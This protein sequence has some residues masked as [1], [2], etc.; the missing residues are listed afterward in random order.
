[1][2][3]A[4]ISKGLPNG[5]HGALVDGIVADYVSHKVEFMLRL[6]V[7]SNPAVATRKSRYRRC[8]F[9]IRGLLYLV[10]EFPDGTRDYAREGGLEI[11]GLLDTT[12]DICPSLGAI[13]TKVS[14]SFFFHSFFVEEWNRFIHFSGTDAALD[15]MED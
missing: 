13:R 4:E 2:T 8:R 9:E 3:P 6:L 14:S 12:P 11:N 1:M 7:P 10:L 15:W 5:F